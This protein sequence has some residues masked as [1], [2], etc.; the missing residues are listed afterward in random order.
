M[1]VSPQQ[2]KQHIDHLRNYML[3][4]DLVI[5]SQQYILTDRAVVRE[6]IKKR[7]E[8]IFFPEYVDTLFW[9]FYIIHYGWD[10]FENIGKNTF[11]IET[12]TKIDLVTLLRNNEGKLKQYKKNRQNCELDL[13]AQPMISFTTFEALCIVFDLNIVIIKNKQ[14]LMMKY[15]SDTKKTYAIHIVDKKYGL[16]EDITNIKLEKYIGNCLLIKKLDKPLQGISSYKI[17]DLH[18][19]CDKFKIPIIDKYGKKKTKPNLYQSIL[20]YL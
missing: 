2:L 16:E 19:I 1:Q 9:C 13:T 14:L 8:N 18:D 20:E 15:G 10:N 17:K 7:E 11:K 6:K 4:S 12:T 5:K 3:T